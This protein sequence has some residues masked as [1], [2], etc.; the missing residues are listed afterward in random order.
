MLAGSFFSLPHFSA[1]ALNGNCPTFDFDKGNGNPSPMA[2]S[3]LFIP[4]RHARDRYSL[5]NWPSGSYLTT[6]TSIEPQRL[7]RSG[8]VQTLVPA[9]LLPPIPFPP[10][11]YQK[12]K[13]RTYRCVEIAAPIPN[14][15]APPRDSRTYAEP[16]VTR[17]ARKRVFLKIPIK[18]RAS[19][20]AYSPPHFKSCRFPKFRCSE[21]NAAATLLTPPTIR[22]LSEASLMDRARARA[23]GVPPLADTILKA[24]RISSVRE[25]FIEKVTPKQLGRSE[26]K[27]IVRKS[28]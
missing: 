2:S 18:M 16:K 25:R 10:S 24:R 6:P 4:K 23:F 1:I 28:E 26:Q 3:A 17:C 27:R 11:F 19:K 8:I 21:L 14:A 15:V 7:R 22:D 9:N 5:M 20:K 13:S 12:R